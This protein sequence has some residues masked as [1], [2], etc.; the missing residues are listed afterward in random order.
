MFNGKLS[1]LIFLLVWT[2]RWSGNK[3]D[4]FR[5]KIN[6]NGISFNFLDNEFVEL[7]FEI[8]W[9]MIMENHRFIHICGIGFLN[10]IGRSQW[11]L[12]PTTKT[13]KRM[14][15]SICALNWCVLPLACMT[16]ELIQATHNIEANLQLKHRKYIVRECILCVFQCFDYV[17]DSFLMKTRRVNVNQLSLCE[18]SGIKIFSMGVNENVLHYHFRFVNDEMVATSAPFIKKR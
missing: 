17:C 12:P 10:L 14:I 3:I 11:M 2:E 4:S 13:P 9:N 7:N 1:R 18:S 5:Y 15:N 8:N 6:K 16:T